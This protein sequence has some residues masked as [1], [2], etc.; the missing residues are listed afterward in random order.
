MPESQEEKKARRERE[1]ALR[2]IAKEVIKDYKDQYRVDHHVTTGADSG[3]GAFVS[4]MAPDVVKV[5][6]DKGSERGY[7]EI[8]GGGLEA[9]FIRTSPEQSG[10]SVAELQ[11]G[12]MCMING[13]STVVYIRPR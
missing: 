9:F 7:V 13:R 4:E 5:V 8:A 10:F 2:D 12:Q 11:N 6:V 3:E 1:K